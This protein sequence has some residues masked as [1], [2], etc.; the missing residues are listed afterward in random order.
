MAP[1]YKQAG[2]S[3]SQ[4][5]FHFSID[6]SNLARKAWQTSQEYLGLAE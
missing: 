5:C 6:S 1:V 3:Q 2:L 4:L